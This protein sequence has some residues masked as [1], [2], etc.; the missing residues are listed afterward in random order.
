[1][2][3]NAVCVQA[4]CGAATSTTLNQSQSS[5]DWRQWPGR[6]HLTSVIWTYAVTWRHWPGRR[7]LTPVTWTSSLDASDL[8]VVTWRHWPGHRHLT[9]VTWTYV[10]TWRHWHGRHHLTPV[11]WT[12]SLDARDLDVVVNLEDVQHFWFQQC[13]VVWQAH[14]LVYDHKTLTVYSWVAIQWHAH[15][16]N[17]NNRVCSR[18]LSVA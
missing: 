3:S 6:R 4:Q 13:I 14:E 7:H 11:I 8:D 9:P 15:L 1:M 2:Q 5:L 16:I 17:S 10:I 18:M 12:S